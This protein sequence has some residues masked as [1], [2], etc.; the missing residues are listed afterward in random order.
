MPSKIISVGSINE[1]SEDVI[2]K[3]LAALVTFVGLYPATY[4][5]CIHYHLYLA[6]LER[7][8]LKFRLRHSV[9]IAMIIC[10]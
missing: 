9:A 4:Y 7:R 5:I 2:Y 3:Q 6:A 1:F 10:G 8:T